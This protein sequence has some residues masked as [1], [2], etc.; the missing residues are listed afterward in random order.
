MAK[1]RP[2]ATTDT[3]VEDEPVTVEGEA[4]NEEAPEQLVRLDEVE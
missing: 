3:E 1:A 4:A 2:V